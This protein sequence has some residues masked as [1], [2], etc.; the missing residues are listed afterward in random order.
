MKAA[1]EKITAFVHSWRMPAALLAVAFVAAYVAAET[2]VAWFPPLPKGL[3]LPSPDS[4]TASRPL[5]VFAG[6]LLNLLVAL[7]MVWI[8]GRYNLLRDMTRLYAGLFVFLQTSVPLLL[9]S[10]QGSVVLALALL[11]SLAALYAVYNKP[12]RTR[13][14]FLAFLIIAAGALVQYA[15]LVYIPVLLLGLLQMRV[16]TLKTLAAALMAMVT[17][18]WICWAFGIIPAQGYHGPEFVSVTAALTPPREIQFFASAAVSMVAGLTFCVINLV[19]VFSYNARA[20]AYN[21]FIALMLF[22]TC[23]AMIA[24]FTNI[25]SYV[26][27]LNVA[28]AYEASQ[29]FV[30]NIKR[31]GYVAIL[32][33]VAVY[34]AL[35][36]WWIAL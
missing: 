10:L 32:G 26:T 29:Y 31:R 5:S 22:A 2:A 28:V 30:I 15:F 13:L 36:C 23:L 4:W 19:K 27:I 35:F 16:F 20:R 21:G 17:P 33:L 34:A 9:C 25:P 18:V 11:M 14:V 3:F 7:L 24:D 12:S 6:V 1:E 8:N